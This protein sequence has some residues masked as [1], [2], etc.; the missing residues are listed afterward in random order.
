[1]SDRLTICRKIKLYPVGDKEE[2]NRTYKF[3][4]DGQYYQYKGLNLL[5]GQ[6]VSKFYECGMDLK[7]QIFKDWQNVNL[8]NTNQFLDLDF[9]KGVDTKSLIKQKVKQD[10]ST[11]IKNGLMKGERN[12]PTYKRDFPLL[13]RGRDLKFYHEYEDYPEFLSNLRKNNDV[14]FIKWVNG[15]VFKVVLGNPKKSQELRSVIQQI[16]EENYKVQGSTIEVNDKEIILNLS[17][18]IP[19][20]TIE[21][22]EDTSIGVDLGIA[23]PAVCA[24]NNNDYKKCF[25]GSKD[26]FLRVRTQ[27]QNQRKRLQ[28]SLKSTSG[29]HGRSKK[30]S[31]LDNL[32]DRESNFVQTYNHY[33]SKQ[34]VDFAIKNKAKYIN[35]EDLSGFDS[36]EFIL[37][38]WSYYQLQQYIT[39]K[40]DKY[41]IEVRYIN[42]YHTSQI[43][44]C[45]GHW[46]EG[47]RINQSTFVCKSCGYSVN[48]DFN[49]AR[50]IAKSDKYISKKGSGS[51]AK[52]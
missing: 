23:V 13:T 22:N 31:S 46:E 8:C 27:L 34:V 33:V 39:Y 47:Q 26:D 18:S 32:K 51:V 36:S 21:L 11:A 7:S 15:I 20:K 3:I 25:I 41:G 48:A 17:I 50:N 43:C 19:K 44:S 24:V 49:A 4:R 5:M 1:M 2:I 42:P 40:A 9:A 6:L 52:E 38:N 12:P 29:G 16:F 35:M 37:R 45:C 28:R 10:F 14:V 30:L